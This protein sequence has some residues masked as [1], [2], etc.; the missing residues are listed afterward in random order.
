MLAV[1][2]DEELVYVLDHVLAEP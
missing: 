2:M 1:Q